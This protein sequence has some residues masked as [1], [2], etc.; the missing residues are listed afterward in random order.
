MTLNVKV[1]FTLVLA[2][3]DQRGSIYSSTL[4]LT[5]VL[6]KVGFNARPSRFTPAKDPVPIV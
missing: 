6:N 1:K 3:K 5:S 4:S 2:T